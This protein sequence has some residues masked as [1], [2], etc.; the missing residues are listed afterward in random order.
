MG[1][2]RY[3]KLPMLLL[4]LAARVDVRMKQ[5]WQALARWRGLFRPP[6]MFTTSRPLLVKLQETIHYMN[7]IVFFYP[8]LLS[9][10]P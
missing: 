8:L 2:H 3:S 7:K 1:Q 5:R 6:T 9:L 4:W 10:I